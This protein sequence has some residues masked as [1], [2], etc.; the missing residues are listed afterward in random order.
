MEHRRIIHNFVVISLWYP[1]CGFEV[2]SMADFRAFGDAAGGASSGESAR[3]PPQLVTDAMLSRVGL[4]RYE[5]ERAVEMMGRDLTIVELGVFGAMWSEHCCYKSSR[6]HLKKLPTTGAHIL[7]GPGEN[8]GV[9]NIGDG[10]AVAFKIESHN[11]PSAVEPFQ[12]AATGVGG[13]IRDVFA[14]GAR[15]IALLDPLRFGLIDEVT[16]HDETELDDADEERRLRARTRYLLGGVVA[17]IAH[18]GNCIG[19]PTVGGEVH[20]DDSYSTNPLVNVLCLG[21]VNPDAIVRGLARGAGNPVLY[22]GSKTGR[23]GLQGATFASVNLAEDA[24]QDRPAVQV[25]DPFYEKLLL[26]ACLE[27]AKM[28]GLIGMQ[29]MGAAGLTSSSC[30][31]AGRGGVGIEMDLDRVPQRADDLTAYEMMLSESQERMVLVVER[32][33]EP[34]FIAAFKKWELD[35]V[36]VGTVIDH[37]VMRIK[38]KGAVVAEIPTAYITTDA[39]EYDRPTKVPE[40]IERM[41]ALDPDEVARIAIH[42]IEDHPYPANL[43][44]PPLNQPYADLLF[45]LLAHPNIACKRTIY[46]QYDHMVRTNTIPPY[47]GDAAVVRIKGKRGAVAISTDCPAHVCY[48]DPHAGAMRAVCEAARNL[49]AVGARPLAIT[50]CLNFGNPEDPEVM[51]QFVETIEGMREAL[52]ALD[53]PVTGGNVS[54]YNETH[55]YAVNPTP[56][57]GMVGVLADAEKRIPQSFAGGGNRL[58]VVGDTD[59]ALDGSSLACCVLRHDAYYGKPTAPDMEKLAA[60]RDLLLAAMDEG[61]VAS[62]HDVGDG[63]IAVCAAEM[64]FGTGLGCEVKLTGYI[65]GEFSDMGAELKAEHLAAAFAESGNRWLVEVAPE[66]S[67]R[68]TSLAEVLGVHVE[69]AGQTTSPD[70]PSDGA[71]FTFDVDGIKLFTVPMDK[72]E[73]AWKEGL[74]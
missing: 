63:G 45:R 21:T 67:A 15:P 51:W 53:T 16:A 12:G 19:I 44:Q 8:A 58:F 43:P 28:P 64:A 49:I 23:D 33:R 6:M 22:V 59:A 26:E 73:K 62:C 41:P 32:G 52:T 24:T 72:A 30:E 54:F 18:Y 14:M 35:A 66:H 2:M 3:I 34:D 11:H 25:G 29:D 13:I 55:R 20:F 40:Y 17:G 37:P 7:Q 5:Y 68:F 57:I 31:M 38:H 69:A 39:P 48:L 46:E 36:E 47:D 9:V 4:K 56:V 27:I 60:A 10:T 74:G 71:T 65:K 70:A 50:N 61:L 42:V 1:S